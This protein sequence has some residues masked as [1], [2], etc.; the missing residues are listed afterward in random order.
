MGEKRYSAKYLDALRRGEKVPEEV[1]L[2]KDYE[3]TED[4]KVYKGPLKGRRKAREGKLK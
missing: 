2:S 1:V 4:K 3:V